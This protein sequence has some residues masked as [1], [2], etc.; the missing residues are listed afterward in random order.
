MVPLPPKPFRSFRPAGPFLLAALL[1]LCAP[2]GWGAIDLTDDSGKP[3]H[4]AQPA[5]RIISLAP[6]VTE[7]IYA[8]GAGDRLVGAVEYSN[9]PEA[10]K[11]IP[12]VGGYS[13]LDLEAVAALKPDLVV[14]WQSGNRAEQ[15]DRLRALGIPVFL[16]EPHRLEDVAASLRALG[17]LAGSEA[18]AEAA[19]QAFND[20]RARLATRFSQRPPVRIFYQI[21]DRPLMTVNGQ[22]LISDA[23]RLCSGENVFAGL[24]QLAP[25]LSTEAVLAADPEALVASGMGEARP[26]WLDQWK[27]WP[28][29]TATARGNLFFVPP[30][31]IQ[32]HTP[33]ILDGAEMLCD[34]LEQARSKRPPGNLRP[35][36]AS[37]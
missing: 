5:R 29:L 30:D 10:A 3:I 31:L 8:A 27:R 20:R 13:S 4:L 22:H 25:T 11:T 33:R 12:R 24:P 34:Q 36:P 18:V 6:H 26:D 19:A 17:R 16:A 28:R 15:L 23:L 37:H 9:Y 14:A 21:W 32:R 2:P 35:A 7:L 1:G